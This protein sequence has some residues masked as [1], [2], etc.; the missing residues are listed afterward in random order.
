[1]FDQSPPP[2]LPSIDPAPSGG[3]PPK[4]DIPSSPVM[5]GPLEPMQP[6]AS[7][8]APA[9]TIP[10][11]PSTPTPLQRPTPPPEP[12][13]IF[14]AVDG[15]GPSV[16]PAEPLVMP[17][18]TLPPQKPPEI[19]A[20]YLQES[21]G[22]PW[23]RVIIIVVVVLLLG[24]LGYGV[25]AFWGQIFPSSGSSTISTNTVLDANSVNLPTADDTNAMP[26]VNPTPVNEPVVSN[27]PTNA[28]DLNAPANTPAVNAPQGTLAP[29]DDPNSKVDS[30]GDGL[31]DYQEVHVYHTDPHNAD[32]DGD[33]LY[34]GEEVN[35]FHTDPLKA[36]TDGDGYSDGQEVKNGFNPLGPGRLFS[37]PKK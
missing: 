22:F 2:N 7:A 33:G 24:G 20:H 31:T 19:P 9:P 15:G 35:T 12:E 10:S 17:A 28:P 23:K 16:A 25:Y 30:D 26:A 13:D 1:M 36:D 11:A 29:E 5:P 37:A 27:A 18:S 14:S 8:P 34:D 32:T 4:L 21:G 6:I 3:M